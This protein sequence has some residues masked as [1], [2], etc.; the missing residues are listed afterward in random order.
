MLKFRIFGS[1]L[2]EQIC[3]VRNAPLRGSWCADDFGRVGGGG[4]C[5]SPDSKILFQ[6]IVGKAFHQTCRGPAGCGGYSSPGGGV[7]GPR[8]QLPAFSTGFDGDEHKEVSCAGFRGRVL[9]AGCVPGGASDQALD[10]M[11]PPSRRACG[12]E[13]V[14]VGVG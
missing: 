10:R 3:S 9:G 1:S 7:F 14:L 13:R 11:P 12:R 6:S 2:T 4:S 5:T 8:E